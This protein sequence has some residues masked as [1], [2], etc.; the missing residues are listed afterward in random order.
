MRVVLS[1]RYV[2][3]I[4]NGGRL[5]FNKTN[6]I[7]ER[8]RPNAAR[9]THRRKALIKKLIYATFARFGASLEIVESEA[10]LEEDLAARIVAECEDDELET[11]DLLDEEDRRFEEGTLAARA[12]LF[13]RS[14]IE[15]YEVSSHCAGTTAIGGDIETLDVDVMRLLREDHERFMCELRGAVATLDVRTILYFALSYI[16][17]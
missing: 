10:R 9:T 15:P 5:I 16:V 8:E 11:G 3:S 2:T 1:F 13:R 6:I 12:R 14:T 17:V 7:Y 4:V